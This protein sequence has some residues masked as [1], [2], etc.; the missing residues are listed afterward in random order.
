MEMPRGGT[1]SVDQLAIDLPRSQTHTINS[2][3]AN[4][5]SLT[6]I[7]TRANLRMRMSPGEPEQP[8]G[9][10]VYPHVQFD[11]AQLRHLWSIGA[12]THLTMVHNLRSFLDRHNP[13]PKPAAMWPD[14]R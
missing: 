3:K 14:R 10:T 7:S 13:A 11:A 5:T 12:K 6:C 1:T 2:D 4:M 9:L 8:G